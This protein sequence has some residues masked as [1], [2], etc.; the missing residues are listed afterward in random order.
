MVSIPRL[1]QH[2]MHGHANI[3]LQASRDN[4]NG[5]VKRCLLVDAI[6]RNNADAGKR[7]YGIYFL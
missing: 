6:W 4:E 1:N 3:V 7:A 5:H 2:V